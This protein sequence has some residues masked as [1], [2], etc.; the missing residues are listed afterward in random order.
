MPMMTF[1]DLNLSY[2]LTLQISIFCEKSKAECSDL[3][4]H[5]GRYYAFY[6]H[7]LQMKTGTII[8][9]KT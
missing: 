3:P 2:A 9:V 8:N 5:T 7:L 4:R 1:I 6:N